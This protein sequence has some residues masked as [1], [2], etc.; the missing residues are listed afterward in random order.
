MVV[1]DGRRNS[2]RGISRLPLSV[3]VLLFGHLRVMIAMISAHAAFKRFDARVYVRSDQNCAGWRTIS[4]AGTRSNAS[5][6][7][8]HAYRRCLCIAPRRHPP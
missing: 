5:S 2:T 8:R 4:L 6:M 7:T 1:A 3:S